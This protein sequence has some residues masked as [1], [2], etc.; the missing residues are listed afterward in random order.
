VS[1]GAELAELHRNLYKSLNRWLRNSVGQ[2]CALKWCTF[3]SHSCDQE[4]MCIIVSTFDCSC[5]WCYESLGKFPSVGYLP[6]V[7]PIAWRQMH[8]W[9]QWAQWGYSLL[10]TMSG[11]RV[12]FQIWKYPLFP[13]KNSSKIGERSEKNMGWCSLW[14]TML[15]LFSGSNVH[16]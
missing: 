11:S 10:V 13:M 14:V 15:R 1:F 9:A 2:G 7:S 5:E 16:F 4:K 6:K 8:Q 3:F 12:H